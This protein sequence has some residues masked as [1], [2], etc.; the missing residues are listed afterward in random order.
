[1]QGLEI[2]DRRQAVAEAAHRG[3]RAHLRAR[4]S[5]QTKKTY[6]G[7]LDTATGRRLFERGLRECIARRAHR[8]QSLATTWCPFWCRI[9]RLALMTD[10]QHCTTLCLFRR[11]FRPF[12]PAAPRI[13]IPLGA[14]LPTFPV[15]PSQAEKSCTAGCHTVLTQCESEHTTP[16]QPASCQRKRRASMCASARLGGDGTPP[17]EERRCR[18]SPAR[19]CLRPSNSG[20]KMTV[21]TADNC[22]W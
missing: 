21:R 16:R 8:P 18:P 9:R 13:R 19:F 5:A 15:A 14:P 7:W 2:D 1:M 20:I 17:G 11:Y 6:P 12:K 22:R 10:S 3:R 4:R